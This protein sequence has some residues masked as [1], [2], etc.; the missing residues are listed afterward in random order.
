MPT[1]RKKKNKK[2]KRPKSL[3][4]ISPADAFRCYIAPNNHGAEYIE[5]NLDVNHCY[6]VEMQV[7]G[8]DD[9]LVIWLAPLPMEEADSEPCNFYLRCIEKLSN[10]ELIEKT[11]DRHWVNVTSGIAPRRLVSGTMEIPGLAMCFLDTP[12]FT[13]KMAG[14]YMKAMGVKRSK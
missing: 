9:M 3:M 10:P 5:E 12:G 13:P 6:G 14:E 4:P 8:T 7:F 11:S 1:E 2:A